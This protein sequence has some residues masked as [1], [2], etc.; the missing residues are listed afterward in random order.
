MD[1]RMPELTPERWQIV[2]RVFNEALAYPPS[3]RAKYVES[4]CG[5][6][7]KRRGAAPVIGSCES[8][9]N[10]ARRLAG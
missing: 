10:I 6:P 1:G 4:S 9:E 7:L 8:I 5:V 2:E 3:E